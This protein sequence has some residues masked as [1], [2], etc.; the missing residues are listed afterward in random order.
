MTVRALHDIER[1]VVAANDDDCNAPPVRAY[2]GLL[3]VGDA[4]QIFDGYGRQRCSRRREAECSHREQHVRAKG[5]HED[6]CAASS[7]KKAPR[8]WANA[9]APFGSSSPIH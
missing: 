4:R 1:V 5:A 7:E 8:T 6:Y 3:D 9:C 2:C